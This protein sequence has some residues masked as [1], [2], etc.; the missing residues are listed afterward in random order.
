VRGVLVLEPDRDVLELIELIL[1]GT[2]IAVASDA[3]AADALIVDPAYAELFERAA[4]L[5]RSRPEL[6]VVCVSIAPPEPHVVEALD[7]IAYL[8]KPFDRRELIAAL[9]G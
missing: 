7:P 9:A 1:R 6:R 4:A 2:G 3:D 8:Q 5:K